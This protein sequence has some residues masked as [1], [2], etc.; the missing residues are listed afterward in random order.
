LIQHFT[1]AGRP[2]VITAQTSVDDDEEILRNDVLR[3]LTHEFPSPYAKTVADFKA[4]NARSFQLDRKIPGTDSNILVP[5]EGLDK[6]WENCKTDKG[7][8][9]GLFYSKYPDSSGI[10]NVSRVGFSPSGN[11]ALVYLGHRSHWKAGTGYLASAPAE[12]QRR[13]G[14][15]GIR[16]CLDVLTSRPTIAR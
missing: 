13:V 2:L 3:H 14:C 9:W 1:L 15:S 10:V 7:C 5:S 6:L 4:M 11:D 8:G 12:E 16:G